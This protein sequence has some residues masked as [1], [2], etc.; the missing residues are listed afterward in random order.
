MFQ[1]FLD[2][3]RALQCGFFGLPDFFQIGIFFFQFGDFHLQDFQAF[4]R[5]GVA[6]V[7]HGLALDFQL[8]QASFELIHRFRFGVHFHSDPAGGFI[9]QIDGFV[10]QLPVGYVTV[11]QHCGGNDGRIGDVDTVMDFVTFLQAAQNGDGVFDA[12]FV[13]QHL[14]KTPF[15]R[16]VF[17]DVLPIFVQCRG[18]DAMQFA[19]R[20]GR[21]QHIAGIHG[22]F[23]LAGA[24]HGVQFVNEQ[25]HLAFQ[26]GDIV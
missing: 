21:F 2:R 18:A 6:F 23:G 1:A 15:Q 4:F 8:N 20:Q 5:R 13:D 12:G 11:R 26:L 14:L 9:D 24:D 25:N 7:F 19:A 10:R 3:R 22:A 17:F 16:G